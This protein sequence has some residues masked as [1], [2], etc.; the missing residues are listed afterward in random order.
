MKLCSFYAVCLSEYVKLAMCRWRDILRSS[1]RNLTVPYP[2]CSHQFVIYI[3]HW[4]GRSSTFSSPIY[5]AVIRDALI[6]KR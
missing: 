2:C 4:R 5:K 3:I 1:Q 6:R